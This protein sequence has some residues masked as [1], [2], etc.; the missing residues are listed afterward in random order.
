MEVSIPQMVDEFPQ[1]MW[2]E[3]DELVPILVGMGAGTVF[4]VFTAGMLAG[5]VLSGIY[6]RYKRNALPGSLHHMIYWW[7]TSG[8]NTVFTN[9]L[10]TEAEQ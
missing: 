6:I 2:W 8:L 1:V 10:E 7:G 4:E 5:L 3:A 9:G